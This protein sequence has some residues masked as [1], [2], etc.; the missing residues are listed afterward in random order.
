[1][2]I[3]SSL[4]RVPDARCKKPLKKHS[5]QVAERYVEM[6]PPIMRW[7]KPRGKRTEAQKGE[8]R[9]VWSQQAPGEY[10]ASWILFLVT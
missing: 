5:W 7:H 9:S 1:M 10:K 3:C 8:Y 6:N 4:E 2:I